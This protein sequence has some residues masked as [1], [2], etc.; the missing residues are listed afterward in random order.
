MFC[1]FSHGSFQ[2]NLEE[3]KK[4]ILH[5]ILSRTTEQ[6]VSLSPIAPKC[7]SWL[8]QL[9]FSRRS[10]FSWCGHCPLRCHSVSD[11]CSHF[12]KNQGNEP[13]ESHS[14]AEPSM[15]NAPNSP[16]PLRSKDF[17]RESF[18]QAFFCCQLLEPFHLSILL[19]FFFSSNFYLL[20]PYS[21]SIL[22][23]PGK[24]CPSSTLLSIAQKMSLCID[25]LCQLCPEP[26][27]SQPKP[28][29]RAIH[30]FLYKISH[31]Y[32]RQSMLCLQKAVLH[33]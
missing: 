17:L 24:M 25:L 31:L 26:E 4:F 22:G 12:V 6:T 20:V 16:W 30:V 23:C 27:I 21:L 7:S 1:S 15:Q 13:E 11:F 19:I 9:F 5:Q 10:L 33:A 29:S 3:K 2:Y 32:K 28:L 18:L 14:S 8:V